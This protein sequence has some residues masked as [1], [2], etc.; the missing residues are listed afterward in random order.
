M[1]LCILKR[2]TLLY[3]VQVFCS[4]QIDMPKPFT[5]PALSNLCYILNS[6]F[7]EGINCPSYLLKVIYTFLQSLLVFNYVCTQTVL[8]QDTL[9]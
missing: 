7:A 8:C 5:K 6:S 2:E 9:I 1:I 3:F 4:S